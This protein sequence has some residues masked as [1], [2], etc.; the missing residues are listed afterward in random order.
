MNVTCRQITLQISKAG[1]TV[2][3]VVFTFYEW[4]EEFEILVFEHFALS[5]YLTLRKSFNSC[6]FNLVFMV[7]GIG[8]FISMIV[9]IYKRI[10][11]YQSNNR[12][13]LK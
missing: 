8:I 11:L 7:W 4:N 13:S 6:H 12:K 2:N 9:F 1:I 3:E 10:K 5:M